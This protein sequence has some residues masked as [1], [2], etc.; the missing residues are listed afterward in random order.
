MLARIYKPAKS[1]MQS[2]KAKTRAWE[3]IFEP[4]SARV[5]DPLMGWTQSTDMNGQV[6]LAFETLQ[7]AITYARSHGIAFEVLPEGKHSK[8]I[9]AYADNFSFHRKQPWT[10]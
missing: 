10:H 9:K 2:G 1:A 3:L 7:E 6:R 4:A 5:P 8:S